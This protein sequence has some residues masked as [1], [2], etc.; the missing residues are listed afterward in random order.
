VSQRTQRSIT[1]QTEFQF[2]QLKTREND[3]FPHQNPSV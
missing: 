1:T 3:A 2:T